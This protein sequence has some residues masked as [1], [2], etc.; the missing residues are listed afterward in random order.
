[1]SF[2]QNFFIPKN[3]L[4]FGGRMKSL[5]IGNGAREHAV[6]EEMAKGT[7]LYAF[8]GARNPGI[9]KLAK[10]VEIGKV[11]DPGPIIKY[12]LHVQP[13]YIFI[14][15]ENPLAVGVGDKLNEN[16]FKVVGPT[17]IAAQLE[18]DKAFCRDLL[19]N[20]VKEGYPKFKVCNTR[21]DVLQA[22]DTFDSEIVVKPAGL[23]G[24]KGVKVQG[25]QLKDLYEVREYALECVEKEVGGSS[26]VVLEE[27]IIGEEYSLQS[28]TDGKTVVPM[29]LVQ[30][31][32][33]AL[34][35]DKGLMTGGMGSYSDANHLLPFVTPKDLD[36]SLRL[37]EKTVQALKEMTG[38]VFK[39]I[40]YGGFMLTKDGPKILEYNVRFG[41]PEAMNVLPLLKDDFTSICMSI[42][43]ENLKKA[44]FENQASVCKYMAPKGYPASP[45]SGAEV[46]INEAE[47]ESFGAKLHYSSVDQ[48]DD[49][50]Y[51]STSRA[52]S[53]TG[54]AP[55]LDEAEQIAQKA[56]STVQCD[57]LFYRKD[58]GTK[59]LV[60]KR[61]DHMNEIRGN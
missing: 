9:I 16:G 50:L 61:I 27:K 57:K 52:F 44:E 25:Q 13:D 21:E 7:E 54:Y 42:L 18:S 47:I 4:P 10:G 34:E 58:I 8:M 23:T 48:K 60:Q 45:Q 26:T 51:T 59:E 30:D 19:E 28:F 56:I 31:H 24:G 53:I 2:I 40:L 3:L 33:H 39:G 12:A 22:I 11:T 38:T 20:H 32:K 17:R 37:M 36:E 5:L 46:S 43:D 6:A 1:M 29:P 15:P 41:D 49:K 55:T 14:G 35:G